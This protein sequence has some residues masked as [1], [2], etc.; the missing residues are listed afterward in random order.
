MVS[1]KLSLHQGRSRASII[2]L[3]GLAAS[4]KSNGPSEQIDAGKRKYCLVTSVDGGRDASLGEGGTADLSTNS[5]DLRLDNNVSTRDLLPPAIDG[6]AGDSGEAGSVD[7]GGVDS[8]SSDARDGANDVVDGNDGSGGNGGNTGDGSAGSGGSTGNG[9][10]T[11]GGSTGTGGSG[12]AR[13]PDV[14]SY[15]GGD[16]GIDVSA[17]QRPPDLL[18][19]APADLSGVY[20]VYPDAPADAPGVHDANTPSDVVVVADAGTD[21]PA[22]VDLAP[23]APDGPAGTCSTGGASWA[24]AWDPAATL[25]GLAVSP[26]GTGWATGEI[27]GAVDFGTGTPVP[28]ASDNNSDAFLVKLNPSSGLATQAFSF[29]DLAGSSQGGTGV[30]VAQAGNV[31]VTGYYYSEIDF[32]AANSDIGTSGLD[33]LAKSSVIPGAPMKFYIVVDGAS[34]GQYVTPIKAHNVDVGTGAILAIASNP[35]QNRTAICGKTSRLLGAYTTAA[36]NTGLLTAGWGGTGSGSPVTGAATYGG[37]MDIVVAVIDASSGQT[38]SG[39][40]LWGRQFGGVGDQVCESLAMD[41]AGNV[42]MAGTY[43]GALSFGDPTLFPALQLPTVGTSGLSLMFVATLDTT[44][45]VQKAASWGTTGVSDLNGV[46]VDSNSNIVIAGNIGASVNMGGSIGA[47]TYY[48]KQDGF[49]AKLNSSLV[50]QW[51][52]SFGDADYNQTAK[53]VA[54]TSSGDVLIGGAFDGTLN[55]LG[56]LTASDNT[57][58]D[59]FTAQL[60]G[61]DGSLICAHPYGDANGTQQVLAVT[62]ATAAT[63]ALADSVMIGGSFSSTIALGS[64]NLF[65]PGN[66]CSVNADCTDLGLNCSNGHCVSALTSKS[67]ISR[68]I[69]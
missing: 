63:G 62:V 54:L 42:V 7:G 38:T 35:S 50:A 41:S 8:V 39:Q 26:D 68:L 20:D 61:S 33:Y 44:G 15:A 18:P 51:A 64:T 10:S 43:N 47:V 36:T 45:T 9:G 28:H 17:D 2:L 27:H 40:I 34:S 6:R 46:A 11:G 21:T 49:V 12:D 23:A 31:V 69:P 66:V 13:G 52:M 32:T 67:F 30:A 4:C 29:S 5:P 22:V 24:K 48:G 37:S 19:D 1:G 16:G 55:R 59:A 53:A 25:Y 56:N 60:S 65:S 3:L 58:L 14:A 57:A